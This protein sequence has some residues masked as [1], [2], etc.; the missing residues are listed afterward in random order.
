M[1]H[2]V[3]RGGTLPGVLAGL[4]WFSRYM[5]ISRVKAGKR[6]T[7]MVRMIPS[8]NLGGIATHDGLGCLQAHSRIAQAAGEPVSG[9][10]ACSRP[11]ALQRS[12]QP[13]VFSTLW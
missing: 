2:S 6:F 11:S 7:G 3:P 10:I 5:L 1:K 4:G 8:R 12:A 9:G 13:G